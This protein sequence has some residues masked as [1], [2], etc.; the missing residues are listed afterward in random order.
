[1]RKWMPR[2]LLIIAAVIAVLL[3]MFF[4][5]GKGKQKQSNPEDS[6]TI[7]KENVKVLTSDM[8]E[9]ELPEEVT[10]DRLVFEK[11]PKYKKGDVIVA[12]CIP[13]AENGFIRRVIQVEKSENSYIFYTEP[14]VLTDV[15]EKAHIV[16]RFQLTEDGMK[17]V[18]YHQ[19][20]GFSIGEGTDLKF[21][22]LSAQSEE[23]G[24]GKEQS[25]NNVPDVSIMPA[26]LSVLLLN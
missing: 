5:M 25:E 18:A 13:Q 3:G 23:N 26:F 14:A 12:G 15:F 9:D 6:D 19:V 8:G 2:I 4:F 7:V 20:D 17:E 11:N 10:E 22:N 1:M 21:R 16:K 24:S